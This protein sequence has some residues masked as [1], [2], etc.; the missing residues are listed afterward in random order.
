VDKQKKTGATLASTVSRR[1]FKWCPICQVVWGTP[2]DFLKDVGLS[3]IGRQESA[4]AGD[5]GLI[6]FNH[7]CGTT[8][9]ITAERSN[10][11]LRQRSNDDE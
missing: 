5:T 2:A 8:L 4:K 10:A 3:C 11:F 7:S 6:M 9:S 1:P